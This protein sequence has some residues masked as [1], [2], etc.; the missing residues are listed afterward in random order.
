MSR[1]DFRDPSD[2]HF[3]RDLCFVSVHDAMALVA[4]PGLPLIAFL[5][6]TATSVDQRILRTSPNSRLP[7]VPTAAP[8]PASPAIPPMIAPLPASPAIPPMMA[9]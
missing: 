6:W 9:P 5:K 1:S 4:E 7:I 8:L 3:S 2:P